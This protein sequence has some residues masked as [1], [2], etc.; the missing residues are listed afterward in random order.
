MAAPNRG[1]NK[2]HGE[3]SNKSHGRGRTNLTV[4]GR[5]SLTVR[6]RTNFTVRGPGSPNQKL[7][8][9]WTLGNVIGVRVTCL[10]E[11]NKQEH[12]SIKTKD[13][14]GNGVRKRAL[15]V[16]GLGSFKQE[17]PILTSVFPSVRM[18]RHRDSDILSV[19]PTHSALFR[20]AIAASAALS[21]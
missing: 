4:R 20:R 14:R 15:T 21:K 6:G 19:T 1:Q 12:F 7:P 16:M 5:T 11:C 9:S 2:Y 3:G 13:S 8:P 17:F 10:G 18:S